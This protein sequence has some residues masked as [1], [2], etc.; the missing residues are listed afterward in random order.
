MPDA[1][2]KPSK[3]RKSFQWWLDAPRWAWVFM[4]LCVL[5]PFVTLGGAV[6]AVIGFLGAWGSA[7]LAAKSSWPVTLRVILCLL[8][9]LASWVVLLVFIAWVQSLRQ[10]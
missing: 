9:T 2:A 8:A 5:I 4:G 3:W 6:P 7:K 1:P 10:S